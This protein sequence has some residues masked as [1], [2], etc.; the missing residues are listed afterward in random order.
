[1]NERKKFFQ[2][3]L[4]TMIKERI[5][6]FFLGEFLQPRSVLNYYGK[7]TTIELSNILRKLRRLR[8][9]RRLL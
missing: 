6:I 2:D 1:L 5:G 9:L 8:R 3:F 4:G 7:V